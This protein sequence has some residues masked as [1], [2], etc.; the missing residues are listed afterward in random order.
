MWL[1]LVLLVR[2]ALCWEWTKPRHPY[3]KVFK[4][5]HLFFCVLSV[6]FSSTVNVDWSLVKHVD[7]VDLYG[8]LFC[9]SITSA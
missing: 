4:C 1:H 9:Y 5:H 6:L 2:V 3:D 8:V 7:D